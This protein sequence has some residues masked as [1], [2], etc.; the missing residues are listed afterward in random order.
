MARD[1]LRDLYTLYGEPEFAG[2]WIDGIIDDCVEAEAKEVRGMARTLNAKDHS[3]WRSTPRE[4]GHRGP[5]GVARRTD[6]RG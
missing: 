2:R 4:R 1:C 3:C 6:D 5:H